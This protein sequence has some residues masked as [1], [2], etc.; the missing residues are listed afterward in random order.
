MGSI[1]IFMM[2]NDNE[3]TYWID[4]KFLGKGIATTALLQLLTMEKARPIFG[5]TAFDNFASQKVLVKCGFV[6]IG[7]DNGFA[8]CFS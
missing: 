1:A 2:G 4:N 5:R 6:K 7:T 3:I 8:K